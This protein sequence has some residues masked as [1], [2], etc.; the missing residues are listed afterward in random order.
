[1]RSYVAMVLCGIASPTKWVT[2]YL[3][4]KSGFYAILSG[5]EPGDVPSV[6]C[7]YGFVDRLMQLP[8]YCREHQ[9]RRKRRRLTKKQNLSS[10]RLGKQQLKED[11]TKVT[12]R[13]VQS[14]P[15]RKWG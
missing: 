1:M 7:F 12:K 3:H 6:G 5:F 2:D 11:K 14:L 13:H 8:A 15:S 4:D 9:T 10:T